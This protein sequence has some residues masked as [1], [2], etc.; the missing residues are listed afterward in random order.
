DIASAPRA[1]GSGLVGLPVW[2]WTTVT[3]ETWGPI[4]ITA[5]VPGLAVTA[6]ARVSRFSFA[7][8]DGHMVYCTVAGAMVDSSPSAAASPGTPYL[9]S[10]G[11]TASPT[12]G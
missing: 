12:C 5:A 11:N 10:Y 2:L 4:S 1:G 9:Q 8:G 6:T 3:P 7:M